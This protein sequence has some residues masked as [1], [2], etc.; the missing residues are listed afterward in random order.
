MP[1][2]KSRHVVSGCKKHK[3]SHTISQETNRIRKSEIQ[4]CIVSVFQSSTFD[5]IQFSFS[6]EGFLVVTPFELGLGL[7]IQHNFTL[8]LSIIFGPFLSHLPL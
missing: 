5:K 8:A 2:Q 3:I 6:E 7:M 4:Y 1:F